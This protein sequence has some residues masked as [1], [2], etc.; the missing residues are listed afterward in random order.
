MTYNDVTLSD[1][2]YSLANSVLNVTFRGVGL[3]AE[4][5]G[6][7]RERRPPRRPQ[8]TFLFYDSSWGPWRLGGFREL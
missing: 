6:I 7:R 5:L 1:A 2:L 8:S 3:A 4:R